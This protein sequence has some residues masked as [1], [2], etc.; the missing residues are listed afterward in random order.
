MKEKACVI[1][2]KVQVVQ[3]MTFGTD[4]TEGSLCV[5]IKRVHN[6]KI[7]PKSNRLVTEDPV[8]GFFCCSF[9]LFL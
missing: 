8:R 6:I 2:Q 1:F 7:A 4:G 3:A 9:V 5:Q